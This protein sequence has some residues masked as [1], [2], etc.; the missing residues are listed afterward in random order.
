LKN[1]LVEFLPQFIST[2]IE[3][4]KK[5]KAHDEKIEDIEV[6]YHI[7]IVRKL[8]NNPADVA[9]YDN[10]HKKRTFSGYNFG[11]QRFDN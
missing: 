2:V 10:R 3:I 8:V 11:T 6:G 5:V 7:K 4:K 1:K 9:Q